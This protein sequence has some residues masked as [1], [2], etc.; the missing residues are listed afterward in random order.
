M[1]ISSPIYG[2]SN[3]ADHVWVFP[4]SITLDFTHQPPQA[5]K[6]CSNGILI[7]FSDGDPTQYGNGI[8]NRHNTLGEDPASVSDS[9]GKLLFYFNPIRVNSSLRPTWN[10]YGDL[11]NGAGDVMI[12]GD[13]ILNHYS[14]TNG[15]VIIPVPQRQGHYYLFILA[16]DQSLYL[17]HIDASQTPI[18]V[19]EKNKLLRMHPDQWYFEKITAIKHSNGIDWWVLIPRWGITIMDRYLIR[20]DT[21]QG[22]YEQKIEEA[23]FSIRGFYGT[24]EIVVSPDGERIACASAGN[25]AVD[26]Y[27]F[28]RCTGEVL[29]FKRLLS[30][31]L[32]KTIFGKDTLIYGR[33]S[34]LYRCDDR[35]GG[36]YGVAFSPDGTRLYVG[37]DSGIGSFILQMDLTQKVIKPFV[38]SDHMIDY[39][40]RGYNALGGQMEIGPDGKI[41]LSQTSFGGVSSPWLFDS[42]TMYLGVIHKPNLAG[43]ACDFRPFDLYLGGQRMS[44]GLPNIPNYNLRLMPEGIRAEAGPDQRLC[45][46]QSDSVEI[47]KPHKEPDYYYRWQP[48]TG[49][50]DSTSP[51]PRARPRRTTT[52]TLSVWHAGGYSCTVT[53]DSVTVW[54]SNVQIDTRGDT[55]I[56]LGHSTPISVT[57]RPAGSATFRWQPAHSLSNPTALQ[58]IATPRASTIYT[59][60][61]HDPLVGIT[62]IDSVRVNVFIRHYNLGFTPTDSIVVSRLPAQVSFRQT[63]PFIARY[64]FLWDFGDGSEASAIDPVHAYQDTGFYQ[65]RLKATATRDDCED[66]LSQTLKIILRDSVI[67]RDPLSPATL[68][69]CCRLLPNPAD[70]QL[71]VVVETSN[72]LFSHDLFL[73]VFNSIGQCVLYHPLVYGHNPIDTSRLSPG[74]YTCRYQTGRVHYPQTERLVIQR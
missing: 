66:T 73:E 47:G 44:C 12:N 72:P 23:R 25:V 48:A 39:R 49:L 58:P 4:D 40:K 3:K 20:K 64:R 38:L 41:Y 59:L 14:A 36:F 13:S 74:I 57:L 71:Q 68:L 27:S 60:S 7:D 28:D 17:N 67:S 19:V 8:R 31:C 45:Y 9:A 21:I 24:G 18:R 46:A 26:L 54:V 16:K 29:N 62:C 22:P 10:R 69:S 6:L 70:D 56:C 32:V 42:S 52:Y 11:R 65:I 61:V 35:S 53:H 5:G 15:S 2:Q 37:L 63:T 30:D 51:N 1:M 55:S 43:A 50:S 34:I 33:D